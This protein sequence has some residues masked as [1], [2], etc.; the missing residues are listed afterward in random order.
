MKNI[1]WRV[2]R[3]I[4]LPHLLFGGIIAGVWAYAFLYLSMH[5]LIAI[6]LAVVFTWFFFDDDDT[7][8]VGILAVLFL[9]LGY[10]FWGYFLIISLAL[11]WTWLTQWVWV[12][13]FLPRFKLNVTYKP[14]RFVILSRKP[15]WPENF[16]VGRI[17]SISRVK[18]FPNLYS[19]FQ[20]YTPLREKY[21][22]LLG[23]ITQVLDDSKL[24]L[25]T[26]QPH[27]SIWDKNYCR[28]LPARNIG[29]YLHY[30]GDNVKVFDLEV[31]HYLT[32][33]L[34]QNCS[35]R[36]QLKLVRLNIESELPDI[37]LGQGARSILATTPNDVE[38]IFH[39]RQRIILAIAHEVFDPLLKQGFLLCDIKATLLDDKQNQ[40]QVF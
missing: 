15:I 40:L 6:C 39:W 11:A 4:V 13:Y 36:I 3:V 18:P 35:F 34:S 1:D 16:P 21:D 25:A 9:I 14:N 33:Y 5:P 27:S 8:P 12:K 2:I 20:V 31:N 26:D 32:H 23:K 22:Q 28:I 17:T 29:H 37:T 10:V 30:L 24:S 38:D 19:V 7:L